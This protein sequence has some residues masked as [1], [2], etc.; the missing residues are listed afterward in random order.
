MSELK[1]PRFNT[2]SSAHYRRLQLV[3]GHIFF[4]S[5][6]A[7]GIIF[8]KE[9]LL[10]FDSAYYTFH[11]ITY[12]DFFIKHERY[13]TY[14]SQ[15][16]PLLAIELGLSLKGVLISYSA[17]FTLWFYLIFLLI[18]H[19]F[20]NAEGGLFMALAFG[21]TM[22]Y[23][24]YAAISELVFAIALAALLLSWL[25]RPGARKPGLNLRM[26][27]GV[28]VLLAA[29]MFVSH[30][31]II[32]PVLVFLG[33]DII[34]H[35]KWKDWPNWG[36]VLLLIGAYTLKYLAIKK[37]PYEAKRLDIFQNVSDVLLNFRE[38]KIY[39]ILLWYFDTEYTFPFVVFLV[40]VSIVFYQ[41]KYLAG[42]FILLASL[43]WFVLNLITYAYLEDKILIMLD[44]YLALFGL[45]WATPIY[46]LLKSQKFKLP[47]S[48]VLSV[49]VIF[50]L[51]RIYNKHTFFKQRLDN[52]QQT[53]DRYVTDEE[54][55]FIVLPE[56][57]NWESMWYPYELPHESLMLSAIK[58][59]EHAATIFVN[60]EYRPLEG[61]LQDSAHFLQFNSPVPK[62][63]LPHQYFQLPNNHYKVIEEVAW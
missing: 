39:E 43:A 35:K 44:G 10:A 62:V 8:Y 50:S 53:L 4:L 51:H 5:F 7:G 57:F 33:Y 13:I 37:D 11:I 47:A 25:T 16:M 63:W 2:Y 17:S 29:M 14:L 40:V 45:I 42:T 24:Y 19:G 59:P 41:R 46:F 12:Q 52:I 21:L 27:W 48:I 36:V 26:H 15:W 6:L 60:Y 23:K 34:Y 22:R 31:I 56:N 20:R 55:K 28:A 61:F 18:A 3:L 30:P 58:G 32:L 38:L 1:I 9:R 54:R 49:L